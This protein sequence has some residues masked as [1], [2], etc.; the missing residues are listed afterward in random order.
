MSGHLLRV[1]VVVVVL[2]GVKEEQEQEQEL[3]GAVQTR[4]CYLGHR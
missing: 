1:V 4:V 2:L 3:G